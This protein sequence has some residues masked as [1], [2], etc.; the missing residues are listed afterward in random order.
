MAARLRLGARL[1]SLRT[2][3]EISGEQAAA[4]LGSSLTKVSRMESGAVPAQARDLETLLG[5]YQV[6]EAAERAELLALL[7][8]SRQPGWWDTFSEPL[9]GGLR[10][11]LMLEAAADIIEV[12]DSQAVPALLQTP[13]YARAL[14]A[15]GPRAAW[16]AGMSPWILSRRRQLLQ[17]ATCPRLWALIGVAALHRPPGEDVSVLRQQIESLISAAARPEITIQL[18]PPDAPVELAVPGPFSVLRFAEPDLP[19]IVFFE[20]LT[21]TATLAKPS[22]VESYRELLGMIIVDAY[23]AE[24][25]Q[26]VLAGILRSLG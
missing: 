2:A 14:A 3:R 23:S 5:L 22:D 8:Q 11:D 17:A 20:Q 24:E 1:R 13:E 18:V 12:C 26:Q 15:A 21:T 6:Q 10:R 4:A 16:R 9:P 25:S 19:D 7:A